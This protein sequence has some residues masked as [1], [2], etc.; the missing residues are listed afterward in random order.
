MVAQVTDQQSWQ[1][2]CLSQGGVCIVAALS[3]GQ[4]Q[5]AQLEV[6]RGAA[7]GRS[8]QPLHF[9]WFELPDAGAA[10]HGGGGAAAA[11]SSFAEQLGLGGRAAP[12]LVAVA[13]RKER[14]AVM[15]GRFQ[16]VCS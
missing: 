15:S 9:A 16:K 6:L 13:P 3:P 10:A 4:E 1:A 7:A 12:A 2:T 11:A 8:E 5:A 14:T